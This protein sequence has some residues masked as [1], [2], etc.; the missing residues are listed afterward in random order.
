M[1]CKL[2]I[3]AQ[4]LNTF[5]VGCDVM[6]KESVVSHENPKNPGPNSHKAALSI[7]KDVVQ[8]KN[9]QTAALRK[10][11]AAATSALRNVYFLAKSHCANSLISPLNE[12]LVQQVSS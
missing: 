9:S 12:L 11:E 6:K 8:M 7:L 10:S 4:V 3:K 5:T 1:Y 2:C